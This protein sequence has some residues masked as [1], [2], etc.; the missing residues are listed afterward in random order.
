MIEYF[1]EK[2]KKSYNEKKILTESK[3]VW[4]LYLLSGQSLNW[5]TLVAN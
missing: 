3:S 4:L 2:K 5:A 1:C